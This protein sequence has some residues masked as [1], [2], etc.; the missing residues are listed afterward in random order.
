MQEEVDLLVERLVDEEQKCQAL[1]TS[2]TSAHREIAEKDRT[3]RL[4]TDE[5]QRLRRCIAD[6]DKQERSAFERAV[7]DAVQGNV[8]VCLWGEGGE[9]RPL[10]DKI[11][12]LENKHRALLHTIQTLEN[13]IDAARL[14]LFV[15]GGASAAP[16]ARLSQTQQRA[17]LRIANA[18]MKRIRSEVLS[19]RTLG[20]FSDLAAGRGVNEFSHGLP[21]PETFYKAFITVRASV[22]TVARPE[23]GQKGYQWLPPADI[24]KR[25]ATLSKTECSIVRRHLPLMLVAYDMHRDAILEEYGASVMEEIIENEQTLAILGESLFF[26]G[27][28]YTLGEYAAFTGPAESIR[29]AGVVPAAM[30]NGG[31]PSTALPTSHHRVPSPAAKHVTPRSASTPEASPASSTGTTQ[32]RGRNVGKSPRLHAALSPRK[33]PATNTPT[34]LRRGP[35][36]FTQSNTAPTMVVGNGG[37]RFASPRT[38]PSPASSSRGGV[39]SSPNR[40]SG[41]SSSSPR[42]DKEAKS[43]EPTRP[44]VPAGLRP[45]PPPPE[46][47]PP[48]PAHPPHHHHHQRTNSSASHDCFL[49]SDELAAIKAS[50]YGVSISRA[51]PSDLWSAAA[52][53]QAALQDVLAEL[54]DDEETSSEGGSPFY[55]EATWDFTPN[56][57]PPKINPPKYT[58]PALPAPDKPV[59]RRNGSEKKEARVV[60]A[61]G[62]RSPA[63]RTSS[64]PQNGES[65]TELLHDD[66]GDDDE[67]NLI[68]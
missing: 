17:R 35:G 5:I 12:M 20:L 28:D 37:A 47:S 42:R 25:V 23:E 61:E 31:M 41:R 52:A 2:L 59:L 14:Q 67:Q 10:L 13:H 15:S 62:T 24:R 11:A 7:E 49:S 64:P 63:K 8:D 58:D 29:E 32:A 65:S 43:A 48:Q 53:R 27:H 57:S 19:V 33:G 44:K 51:P 68:V 34:L 4:Q 40:A 36:M 9:P 22:R 66:D 60:F 50:S 21:K 18:V 30:R 1:Q 26:V 38:S 16:N 55:D 54:T 56:E 3:L 45:P 46:E 39:A 6:L